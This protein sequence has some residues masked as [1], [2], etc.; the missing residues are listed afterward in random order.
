MPAPWHNQTTS[1][2]QL[3]VRVSGLDPLLARLRAASLLGAAELRPASLP[4]AAIL[5]VRALADPLPGALPIHQAGPRPTAAWQRAAAAALDQLA[6]TAARPARGPVSPGAAAV[7]FADQAELL[8]CL[9]SDWCAG[10]LAAR[11]WWRGLLARA[12]VGRAVVMAWL[13]TPAYVPVAL[14]HLARAGALTR[15]VS[16]LAPT[17]VAGLLRAVIQTF[18]LTELRA[19]VEDLLQH[20]A[21]PGLFTSSAVASAAPSEAT[22]TARQASGRT[23]VASST[24]PGKH[25]QG[26]PSLDQ[27]LP[28]SQ[29]PLKGA[30]R[31]APPWQPWAPASAT[32]G[33]DLA[34]CCLIGIGLGLARA[35][36]AVRGRPFAISL[37]RWQATQTVRQPSGPTREGDLPETQMVRA[38]A[39]AAPPSAVDPSGPTA[40]AQ[41]PARH[42]GP[43]APPATPPESAEL[44]RALSSQVPAPAAE[45]IVEIAVP[46]DA[47]IVETAYGGIFYLIN[48]A[49]FLS[50]YGDFMNPAAPGLAL[51]IWDFVALFGQVWLGAQIATDPVWSLLARLAGRTDQMPPGTGFEPPDRWRVPREWLTPFTPLPWHWSA[52]GGR[53]RAWWPERFTLLDLP[54]EQGDPAA[55]LARECAA[56]AG[57]SALDLRPDRWAGPADT[58]ALAR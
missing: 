20:I 29:A 51:P 3:R 9:A 8:A 46:T 44:P 31:P 15:F 40:D 48:V 7:I 45:P 26:V 19:P 39:A 22:G 43:A 54:L 25:A 57:A 58:P 23:Q 47:S 41:A 14:D 28:V 38:P 33:L 5:C 55:Q 30:G 27:L 56:Y 17:E 10:L 32:A 24:V 13:D 49:L 36:L 2:G 53:L 4:P 34:Q 52:E 35:P 6:R 11:W 12:P 18:G 1:I 42:S 37:A 21:S 50:L 16:R